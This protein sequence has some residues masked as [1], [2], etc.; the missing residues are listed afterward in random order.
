M[1]FLLLL[2]V[3]LGW[4]VHAADDPVPQTQDTEE[5]QVEQD[6]DVAQSGDN[7]EVA[8]EDDEDSPERFIPTEEISQ[9]LGVSF[10]VDI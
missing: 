10:P 1:R 7:P 9:D 4:S 5:V 3:L 6:D 8:V 2:S